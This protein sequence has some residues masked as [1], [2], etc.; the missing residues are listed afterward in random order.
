MRDA[1]WLHARQKAAQQ[2]A[3]AVSDLADKLEY[4]SISTSVRAHAPR[5]KLWRRSLAGVYSYRDHWSEEAEEKAT[6]ILEE[7]RSRQQFLSK[8]TPLSTESELDV[9]VTLLCMADD[10]ILRPAQSSS[11]MLDEQ[12]SSKGDKLKCSQHVQLEDI[13]ALARN[14]EKKAI[15]SVFLE[16]SKHEAWRDVWRD[17]LARM[18]AGSDEIS[19]E[20]GGG[21]RRDTAELQ[22]C[23]Y[24]LEHGEA[25]DDMDRRSSE[26][27]WSP[28]MYEK[29]QMLAEEVNISVVLSF[30][31][32]YSI[33]IRQRIRTCA[34]A[35]PQQLF[36]VARNSTEFGRL[37]STFRSRASTAAS[38]NLTASQSDFR[39]FSR[40]GAENL[41]AAAVKSFREKSLFVQVK[42]IEYDVLSRRIDP[43]FDCILEAFLEVNWRA[44]RKINS[45]SLAVHPGVVR[46]L[47]Q[48]VDKTAMEKFDPQLHTVEDLE[49]KL[50]VAALG[51]LAIFAQNENNLIYSGVVDSLLQVLASY[52]QDT[53]QEERFLVRMFALANSISKVDSSL[54]YLTACGF[55]EQAVRS[56][57][58]GH[59]SELV[60]ESLLFLAINA[61]VND[62]DVV[63]V[64]GENLTEHALRQG[65]RLI[66]DIDIAKGRDAMSAVI[67]DK[68]LKLLRAVACRHSEA[69]RTGKV[70]GQVKLALTHWWE[71]RSVLENAC[72]VLQS[73]CWG[74]EDA[75]SY[76]H[77]NGLSPLLLKLLDRCKLEQD[78]SHNLLVT[79][80]IL[81]S[82]PS[83]LHKGII[84]QLEVLFRI[85]EMHGGAA[86]LVENICLI[87]C[88]ISKHDSSSIVQHS[89]KLID[90]V[91]QHD[92]DPK[93]A[94]YGLWMLT[95]ICENMEFWDVYDQEYIYE[96]ILHL[97]ILH[98]EDQ[99]VQ[100]ASLHLTCL[101]LKERGDLQN[102]ELLQHLSK[103][104]EAAMRAHI[105]PCASSSSSSSFAPVFSSSPSSPASTSPVPSATSAS[106]TSASASSVVITMVVSPSSE[107]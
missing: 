2:V 52:M 44:K 12:L 39:S 26:Q 19:S 78:S 8:N 27:E 80:R 64:G 56:L 68:Y 91:A 22:V 23:L 101:L 4:A 24:I 25:T 72:C 63:G 6:D 66:D 75:K 42:S 107:A 90:Y 20:D 45:E 51:V 33:A 73:T 99:E 62:G 9:A 76:C 18:I 29:L 74:N 28:E 47:V 84:S 15:R 95:N 21:K 46:F 49:R 48:C 53:S 85:L 77:E 89:E 102:D 81:S 38:R 37:S 100:L 88:N 32:S 94:R 1:R 13:E 14:V 93:I 106:A 82:P 5:Y 70:M 57:Q 96:I 92:H 11:A 60:S 87:F 30:L 36:D 55:S 3:D 31:K 7:E 54:Q 41:I 35:A 71:S 65:S 79:L 86:G 43:W 16:A 69:M 103:Q 59:A 34:S 10:R 17:V 105:W 40:A 98:E 83:K 50:E 61:T 67:V 97:M 58:G 104:I